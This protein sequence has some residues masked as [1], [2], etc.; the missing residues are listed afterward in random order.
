MEI[1]RTL[2]KVLSFLKRL[3]TGV[4]VI[5]ITTIAI[6]NK[7]HRVGKTNYYLRWYDDERCLVYK[8]PKHS[9]LS[10]SVSCNDVY[11]NDKYILAYDI[12]RN[13]YVIQR[14]AKNQQEFESRDKLFIKDSVSFYNALDS[15]NIDRRSLNYSKAINTNNPQRFILKYY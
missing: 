7:P 11:Y 1:K 2:I 9:W 6:V 5:L 12:L 8:G 3:L 4:M 14:I 15:L 10:A 13:V